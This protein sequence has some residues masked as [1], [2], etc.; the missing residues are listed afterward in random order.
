M[1]RRKFN[2]V[3]GFLCWEQRDFSAGKIRKL[4]YI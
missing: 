4:G 3:S 1:A 2:V